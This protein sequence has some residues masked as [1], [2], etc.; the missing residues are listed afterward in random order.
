L[1]PLLRTPGR[2]QAGRHELYPFERFTEKAKKVLTL[3]QDEAEKSHHSYIG[4]EHLLL[5]LL[6]ESD[7]LAAKVLDQLGVEIDTV[8]EAM[9]SILGRNE[10]IIVQQIIPTSRMKKVIELAFEEAKGSNT[11]HVGTG[12]LLVGI[13]LEGECIAAHVLRDLGANLDTVRREL[14]SLVED[15]GP[16]ETTLG[17]TDSSR[18]VGRDRTEPGSVVHSVFRSL[19]PFTIAA[20][21]V[22]ALTEEESAK[23]ALGYVG[24][25]HLLIGVLRQAEG[26][27]ARA[28]NNLG[29]TLE[30]VREEV[31]A[32]RRRSGRLFEDR[33]EPSRRFLAALTSHQPQA[34]DERP[35][36]WLDTQDLL[37]AITAD[38][39]DPTAQ[40]LGAMG[41][42]ASAIEGEVERLEKGSAA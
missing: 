26:I 1:G 4:T 29:V 34:G 23:A 30:Q 2:R 31:A 12:H 17:Q 9:D 27:G 21:S 19:G 10:G 18:H 7:G 22:M 33:R 8:R 40:L 15:Q 28:L 25:E 39:D 11:T 41:A 38:G 36:R 24:T 6:R 37:L 5:G 13:L 35:T 32:R 14:D 42:S 16:E 20:R 3:A